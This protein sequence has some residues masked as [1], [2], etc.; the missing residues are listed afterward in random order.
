MTPERWQKVK[1]ILEQTEVQPPARRQEW[2]RGV[3]GEDVELLHEIES[4]LSFEGELD[5]FIEEPALA[6]VSRAV[7]QQDQLAA[8]RKVGPYRLLRLLGRGG[9]GSVYLAA[10]EENFEQRVALKILSPGLAS[11]E[12]VQRF[13]AERQIL[14]RLEHPNI[15]RLLDG[16]TSADGLPYF[17]MEVVEGLSIDLYCDEQGLGIRERLRLFLDLCSALQL[18]HQSLV[19]HRDLKPGNIL[20]DRAGVPKLLDFGIAKLLHADGAP[21]TQTAQA[22]TLY[23]ASP[24]QLQGEPIGTTSDVYSL[25]VVMYQVLTGHLPGKLEGRSHFEMMRAICE[26]ETPPASQSVEEAPTPGAVETKAWR[27]QLAGDVDAI[28]A[29]ALRKEPAQRYASVQDLAADI[30][31]Y[32][33]HHPVLARQG[34]WSY[35]LGKFLRRHRLAVASVAIMILL[36]LGFT[37]ALMDKKR[38]TEIARDRAEGV[39]NFLIDLFQAAAPDQPAG[40]EP[41]LRQLLARGHAKLEAGLEQDPDTRA[42][43]QLK[44]G[45]VYYKLGDYAEAEALFESARKV[46]SQQPGEH[47]AAVLSGLAGVYFARGEVDRAE[48][49]L[50]EGIAIRRRLGLESSLLKPLSSLAAILHNRGDL[51]EAEKIYRECLERRRATLGPRHE[52]VATSLRSLAIVLKDA[53]RTA[54]AEPL[55]Q[56]ALSIREE[57]FGSESAKVAGVLTSLAELDKKLGNLEEAQLQLEKAL[58]IYRLKLGERHLDTARAERDLA[59]VQLLRGEREQGCNLLN[60]ALATFQS[61]KSVTDKEVVGTQ[62]LLAGC[63]E[64]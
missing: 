34:N 25:A 53:G 38:E 64:E 18:A 63:S 13:E 61:I 2:L 16:G 14:A 59:E 62:A 24:E 56:E 40:E 21:P 29:R 10:R 15:A 31:R 44:L 57:V 32:L 17:A 27:R 11:S 48:E 52:D 30:R 1:D 55:L 49:M 9:M 46:L 5:G 39:S 26:E 47:L 37:K 43:L 19:V 22:F 12:S 41:T 3:C 8:T 54:E 20:V 23:Y 6:V 35:R 36:A 28:L 58:G 45:E 51:T 50:R 60:R 7:E 42:I 4:L 33:D